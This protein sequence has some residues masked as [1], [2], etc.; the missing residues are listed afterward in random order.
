M[1]T[2][3]LFKVAREMH[4]WRQVFLVRARKVS[5]PDQPRQPDSPDQAGLNASPGPASGSVAVCIPSS[6]QPTIRL[7]V[8]GSARIAKLNV[9]WQGTITLLSAEGELLA[10]VAAV[11]CL[12]DANFT[13]VVRI[14]LHGVQQMP[15]E[16][17]EV[18]LGA[19][20]LMG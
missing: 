13:E 18:L 1:S 3:F 15:R 4:V 9:D 16:S 8:H 2:T 5:Q 11:R 19:M 12:E 17:D 14:D 7:P 20:H 10:Q 6:W